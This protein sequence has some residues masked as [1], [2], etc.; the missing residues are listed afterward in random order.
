LSEGL[1]K[2]SFAKQARAFLNAGLGKLDADQVASVGTRLG[3]TV[4]TAFID[5]VTKSFAST[6]SAKLSTGNNVIDSA[7]SHAVGS[8]VGQARTAAQTQVQLGPIDAV[9]VARGFGLQAARAATLDEFRQLFRT[10]Q[11]TARPGFIDVVVADPTQVIPPVAPWQAS[12]EGRS[13]R[14]VY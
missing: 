14:P 6:I 7:M 11:R 3:T 4:A 10:Y 5:S 13:G 9:A 8:V 1:N 12:L 2:S